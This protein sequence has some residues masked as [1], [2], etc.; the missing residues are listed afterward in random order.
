MMDMEM[1][2]GMEDDK[3]MMDA[4]LGKL[5][6][7]KDYIYE[8]LAEG[9]SD[10]EIMQEVESAMTEGGESKMPAMKSPMKKGMAE[11]A[12]GAAEIAEGSEMMEDE[13]MSD[14]QRM[15]RDYFKPKKAAPRQGTGVFIASMKSEPKDMMKMGESGNKPGKMSKMR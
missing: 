7:L 2:M 13:T 9:A 12:E 15:K 8:L 1:D 6:E 10:K 14:L 5:S 3:E 11:I 4:K